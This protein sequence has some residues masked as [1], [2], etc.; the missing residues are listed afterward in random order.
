MELVPG[1]TL[2]ERVAAGAIPLEEVLPIARQI[3]EALE[4]AHERGIVHRDLKPAN[5]KVT[6]E[7]RV[8]VLDFGLA[9]AL[10]P[11]LASG[12]PAS[13]PTLTM[14][15]TMAG[16]ILGTA[17]YMAPEQAKG[18]PVDR[19][20]DI[21]AFGVV[22]AEMLTGRMMY[23]GET[24]SETLASV[25]KD[26][27][28]LTALPAETPA[29][30]RRLL[31]RCLDK[32]PQRR[33]QAI[34]EARIAFD[35][36]PDEPPATA[37]RSKH[38]LIAVAAVLALGLAALAAI[39]FTERPPEP[40]AIRFQI[41]APEKT[42]FGLGMAISPDG[43]RLAFTAAVEG[44]P[45]L[46]VR[47]LDSL[48]AQALPGTDGGQYPFWSPDSRSIGFL[49]T[50]KLKKVEASGGPPQTLCDVPNTGVGASW[51]LDGV[52]IFG[53]NPSGLFRVPQ[54]GGAAA[55][56]TEL[57]STRGESFHGRPWFLPDGRHFLF[58]VQNSALEKSGIFLGS[59]DSK[60][61]TRL[62]G[63]LQGGVYSPPT[64]ASEK[65][66]LL[67][68][69]DNTLMA[70]PLDAKS[71]GP[72]GE[73]F[74]VAQ[75]VGSNISFPFLSASAT[76]ALVYRSG[77][78]G[79]ETQLAWFDREGKLMGPVGPV[80]AYGD[81][82]LSPDGKRAA[83]SKRDQ[84]SSNWDL[85]LMDVVHQ[86]PTRFTFDPA[87]EYYPAWSPDGGR[88]VFSS[89]RDGMFNLYGKGS[90]GTGAEEVVL[91][92]NLNKRSYDWSSDGRYL[93]FSVLDP[94]TKLDLWLLPDPAGSG[95]DRKPRPFL[96]T[97][98]NETQGQFS[99]VQTG[100]LR[101][102]AYVSDES[103]RPE[104]YVQ[105]FSEMESASAGKFQISSEGGSQPRWRR[106][107]KEI[108]YIALDGKL[109]AVDVKMTPQFEHSI[110]KPLFRA[111][112]FGS[113]ALA[114][115]AYFR[116]AAAAD[117]KRFLIDSVA[118]ETVQ[119]PIT[120]VLNWTAGLKK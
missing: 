37:P 75:E 49:T 40:S 90:G 13:S 42:S 95:G 69:R 82:A 5:V 25:I 15:A 33:L 103:G 111:R 48:P 106:D 113:G 64:T 81:L 117:G 6:P 94:K 73:A 12:D 58:Y 14:R 18:K 65:G 98:Y 47:P 102:I 30:I 60:D 51:G 105:P 46:F 35:E 100:A 50:G 92:S 112:I 74:P 114:G 39:H 71:F 29:A 16:F 4:Y 86:V 119:A 108:Y 97:P 21:W 62:V 34:G 31:R 87:L 89:S 22:L 36:P 107:G 44:R 8:K 118:E 19:R 93:L 24:V 27:P 26:A 59:L 28:D 43:K 3:A 96:T 63:A 54:A 104:V 83:V 11:D 53:T 38:W 110:P 55:P 116:Y 10:A 72:A 70:L 17:S 68:L 79:G 85:W 45:M 32:D 99:P 109:M 77:Q 67:F 23:Q 41:P 1:P 57:D 76:G 91:K 84:Q 7:G 80:G 9:K 88:I 61:R 120:V 115:G 20:A 2:A 101:W 78:A 52:I 56:L 66:H